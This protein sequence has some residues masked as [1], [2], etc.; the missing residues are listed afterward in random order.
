[1]LAHR[2][3]TTGDAC[4]VDRE[5]KESE[6]D[7][8]GRAAIHGDTHAGDERGAGRYQEAHEIGNIFRRRD[9]LE[10]IVARGF[11]THGFHALALGRSLLGDEALPGRGGGRGRRHG[12]AQNIRRRAEIGEALREIDEPRV[13]DAAGQISGSRIA[14]GGADDVDDASASMRLHHRE[15]GARHPHVAENLQAPVAGP[16]LVGDLEEVAAP[17]GAR[18]IHE[19]IDPPEA[20]LDGR[21]DPVHLVEPAQIAGDDEHLGVRLR[22]DLLRRLLEP[23]L[24]A[25][26]DRD[27]R[28]L[29]GEPERDGPPDAQTAPRHQ[30]C[31]AA[32]LEIH[33]ISFLTF[34]S[35][36]G[37]RPARPP[38]SGPRKAGTVRQSR[39]KIRSTVRATSRPN[40]SR[41]IP[42]SVRPLS[43]WHPSPS[44]ARAPAR[45]PLAR[46]W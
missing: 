30:R 41:S 18:V 13:R 28:A 7:A 35:T 25:R 29:G 11:G 42:S 45:L 3:M 16:L 33:E 15:D 22:L 40:A 9:P 31:L 17:D 23:R 14:R 39:W 4:Q 37:A 38:D 1:M 36:P 5:T 2:Y 26:A 27:L 21:G 6:I 43:R 44:S 46:C 20:L 24:V 10:R 8:A 32:Q 19:D 34:T 12:V